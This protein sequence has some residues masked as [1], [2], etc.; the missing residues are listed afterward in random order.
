M[1][2]IWGLR[3]NIQCVTDTN[4]KFVYDYNLY[5]IIKELV[6]KDS[7]LVSMVRLPVAYTLYLIPYTSP[8]PK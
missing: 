2:T 5:Y 6:I 3:W 8:Y 4:N 7:V 1:I